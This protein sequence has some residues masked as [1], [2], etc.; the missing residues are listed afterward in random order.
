MKQLTA[1]QKHSILTHI[2]A[3]RE[4]ERPEDIAALHG[5]SV[6]RST[7][8]TWQQ[9][10]DGTPQS[11]EHKAGAGRPRVLSTAQVTRHVR[12]RVLAAN[13]R[14][15]AVHYSSLLPTVQ[16]VTGTELS[17]RSLRRYGKEDLH[18]RQK[19]GK[20]RTAN[21]SECTHTQGEDNRCAL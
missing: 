7:L 13:R 1:Q 8:Y 20:K 6:G 17:L 12:P 21:E 4:G 9:H 16:R 14:G 19:R 15:E 11:L 3:R 5:V 18:G 10:W 2:Q